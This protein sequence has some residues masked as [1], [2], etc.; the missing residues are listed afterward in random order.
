MLEAGLGLDAIEEERGDESIA[1]L[2][3]AAAAIAF[4]THETPGFGEDV[5]AGNRAF[6]ARVALR[7][8]CKAVIAAGELPGDHSVRFAYDRFLRR[9]EGFAFAPGRN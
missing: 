5:R 1:D 6:I 2:L 4:C 3:N 9:C 8:F 7:E